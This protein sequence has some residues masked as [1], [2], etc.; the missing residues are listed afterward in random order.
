MILKL[1]SKRTFICCWILF[2]YWP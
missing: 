2:V 1:S